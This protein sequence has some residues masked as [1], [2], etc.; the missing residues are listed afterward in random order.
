MKLYAVLGNI[1]YAGYDAP[2]LITDDLEKAEAC[3]KK[4]NR[5]YDIVDIEEYELNEER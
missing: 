2:L 5:F 1:D 4:H 3:A